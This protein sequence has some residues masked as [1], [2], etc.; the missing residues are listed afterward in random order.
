M[1]T[2]IIMLVSVALLLLSF[3]GAAQN[4]KVP[5]FTTSGGNG[6]SNFQ[7]TMVESTVGQVFVGTMR[8]GSTI[9]E[10]GFLLDT[11]FRQT[12]LSIAEDKRVPRENV[13][14]QNYPNPFNPTTNIQFSIV[15]RQLT[16]V[17]VYDVLGREVSTIVNEVKES[18][19]YTVQFDAS[20]LSSGVYFY[21]IQAGDFAATKKLLLLR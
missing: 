5:W 3:R 17:K 19:T 2:K 9:I 18:G 8:A 10:A 15:N 16:I 20:G 7:N 11:L 1:K 21:H 4:G 14:H 12:I 13:L 6:V